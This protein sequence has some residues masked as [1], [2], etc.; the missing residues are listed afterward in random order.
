MNDAL[1]TH[2]NS[3]SQILDQLEAICRYPPVLRVAAHGTESNAVA[4]EKE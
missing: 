1:I 4:P 2:I 3:A